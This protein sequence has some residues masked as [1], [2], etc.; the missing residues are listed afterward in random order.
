VRRELGRWTW[1]HDRPERIDIEIVQRFAAIFACQLT[2]MHEQLT[3]FYERL[4]SCAPDQDSDGPP[5]TV[6]L[7]VKERLGI[8]LAHEMSE[9]VGLI[10]SVADI[11]AAEVTADLK[12]ERRRLKARARQAAAQA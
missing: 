1:K 11:D 10:A 12:E 6:E 2:N 8:I 3:M 5:S 4:A 7:A 9:I